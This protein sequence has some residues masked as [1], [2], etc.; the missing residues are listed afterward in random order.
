MREKLWRQSAPE[1]FGKVID[2][3]IM[4]D[5]GVIVGCS[6]GMYENL[7]EVAAILDGG[8]IG[9]GYFDLVRVPVLLTD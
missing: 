9:N 5:Q 4:V 1:P 3:K 2:G 6:G 7:V 8:S